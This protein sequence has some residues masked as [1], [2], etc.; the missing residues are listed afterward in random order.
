MEG[1]VTS[2]SG[3]TLVVN[4]TSITGSGGPYTSWNISLSGAPGPQGATGLTGTAGSN[5]ATGAT[6]TAGSNGATGATGE[7]GSAGAT[8]ATGTAGSNGATGATATNACIRAQQ[9][10]SQ[11]ITNFAT[12]YY[13]LDANAVFNGDTNVFTL[14]R[15]SAGTISKIKISATG[16]YLINAKFNC[17]GYNYDR[18]F[19]SVIGTNNTSVD[20]AITEYQYLHQV[21]TA[22]NG[23][24]SDTAMYAASCLLNVTSQP[25]WVSMG[26]LREAAANGNTVVAGAYTPFLEIIKLS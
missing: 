2:Y 23:G 10:V 14:E 5:G 13:L 7:T 6:G 18:F 19:R 3:T 12:T 9:T 15:N 22:A 4:V 8:G 16:R 21:R 17:D 11:T 1:T 20:T 25:I 26:L 24:A